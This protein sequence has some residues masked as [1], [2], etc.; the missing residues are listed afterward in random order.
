MPASAPA[1]PCR[2]LCRMDAASGLCAGCSR[3][4]E[5]IAGWAGMDSAA[6][7]QTL[8]RIAQRQR[9]K[10]N[11]DMSTQTPAPPPP[12]PVYVCIGICTTDPDSGYC[13]G[14]GRPPEGSDTSGN[15]PDKAPD[16]ASRA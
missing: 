4:L 5:E 6:K 16:G 2:N 11:P 13:I 14:C 12:S 8:A 1:S 3:T 9:L 7:E 15:S 10:E